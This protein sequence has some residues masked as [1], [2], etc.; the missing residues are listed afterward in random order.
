LDA[1]PDFEPDETG[2]KSGTQAEDEDRYVWL[3]RGESKAIEEEM[4]GRFQHDESEEK[5]VG[6]VGMLRLTRD[7]MIVKVPSKRMFEFARKK[8]TQYL[9]EAVGEPS[10]VEEDMRKKLLERAGAQ[11]SWPEK[12]TVW[13]AF[14]ENDDDCG[15]EESDDGAIF[16]EGYDEDGDDGDY[17]DNEEMNEGERAAIETYYHGL[18]TRFLKDAVP[19]L[20]QMTPA[21]AAKDPSMR[22]RL[23]DLIKQHIYS[24]EKENR[25]KGTKISIAWVL[26]ELGLDELR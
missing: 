20:D 21:E 1:K 10:V 5:G 3:R 2:S 25:E 26:E 16:D 12:E 24:I 8:V 11:G 19:A 18:Y 15:F 23:I 14:A 13:E 4:P 22:P 9:G 7:A 6:V 17:D